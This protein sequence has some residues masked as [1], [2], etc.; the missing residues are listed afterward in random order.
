MH[1]NNARNF[2]QGES[3]NYERSFVCIVWIDCDNKALKGP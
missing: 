3:V 2:Q 1:G